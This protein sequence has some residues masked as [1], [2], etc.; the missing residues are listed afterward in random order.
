MDDLRIIEL[1]FE[2]DEQA[3]KET[4]ENSFGTLG[5]NENLGDALLSVASNV[6]EDN[7][8]DYLAQL[9]YYKEG[10]FL[11]PLDEES[12]EAIFKPL[13]Q[14]SIGYMLLVRFPR[15]ACLKSPAQ[16]C[17]CS[18]SQIAHLKNLQKRSML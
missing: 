17:P 9:L 7:F 10:S 14:N 1:Y 5:S 11:E 15:C 8:Q 6:M 4:L 2:R 18:G 12:L 16:C 13:L 3:I